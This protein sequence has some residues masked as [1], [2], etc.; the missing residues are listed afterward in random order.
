MLTKE[1]L[2]SEVMDMILGTRE[3]QCFLGY[4]II[5]GVDE[6]TISENDLP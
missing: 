1:T 6:E 3:H 4:L 5:M 2:F